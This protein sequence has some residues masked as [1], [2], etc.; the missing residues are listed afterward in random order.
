MKVMFWISTVIVLLANYM[1]LQGYINIYYKNYNGGPESSSGSI[2][3][4]LITGVVIFVAGIVLYCFGKIK[5]AT[6]VMG[7]PVAASLLYLFCTM[8]L[9][10]LLGGKMN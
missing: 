9:P 6:A 4:Y 10:L 8:I 5:F 1:F 7:L 2:K 3:Y